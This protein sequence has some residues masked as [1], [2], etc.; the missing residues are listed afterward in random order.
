MM[1]AVA[2]TPA[3]PATPSATGATG[4][5]A[6]PHPKRWPRIVGGVGAATVL[7]LVFMAY[8]DPHT[9]VDLSNRVW[10]CIG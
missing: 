5:T 6:M 1:P 2:A 8:L 9:M 10:S 7:A 4:A 3:T